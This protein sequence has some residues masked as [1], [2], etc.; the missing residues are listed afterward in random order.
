MKIDILYRV[1]LD[2][3]IRNFRKSLCKWWF[4]IKNLRVITPINPFD[5]KWAY[6]TSIGHKF[7]CIH[8]LHEHKIIPFG[9]AW[10]DAKFRNCW[11]P[12]KY[13]LDLLFV[14]FIQLL[15]I[16]ISDLQEI[17]TM[18]FHESTK[19]EL[20]H[21]LFTQFQFNLRNKSSLIIHF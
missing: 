11:T 9:C 8:F 10:L 4:P 19:Q 12:S 14:I 7:V 16:A 20:R 17:P 18:W 21:V 2:M 3:T 15:S 1:F 5:T 6:T 13:S